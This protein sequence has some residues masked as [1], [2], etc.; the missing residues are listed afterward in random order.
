MTGPRATGFVRTPTELERLD[1]TVQAVEFVGCE[2]LSVDFLSEPQAVA[3]VLPPGL[4]P[5]ET[6]RITVMTGRWRSNC[7]GDFAGGALY[8][9]ARHEGVEGDY[10]LAMYMDSD[11][12]IAFGRD[13]FGE[14]K[15]LAASALWRQGRFASGHV[16]R[17]GAR[18]MELEVELEA[19]GEPRVA[20]NRAFNVKAMLAP[21]RV[22]L[23]GDAVITCS[24]FASS[25]SVE[26]RGP[27]RLTLRGTA[28]DPLDTLPVVSVLGGRYVES[29]K[30][31]TCRA[32]GRIAGDDFLPY[33]YGR[34]DDWTALVTGRPAG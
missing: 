32:V 26:R 22:G 34:M 31:A 24:E 5:A 16:E 18:L 9:A 6:P 14:P 1:A 29:D 23:V 7:V 17:G 12:A 3:H 8:V 21:D 19:T 13:V 15:K 25:I 4:E 11:P 10:V 30:R 33:A 2:T 28:H 20:V 27:A